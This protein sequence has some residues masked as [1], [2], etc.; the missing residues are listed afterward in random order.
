MTVPQGKGWIGV[1][2]DGTLAHYERW[3]RPDDI[4]APIAPMVGRVKGW[5]ADDWDVRIFTARGSLDAADEALAYPAI[6]RWC[7]EHLGQELPITNRKDVFMVALYDDRAF[8]V[9]K[10]TGHPCD[11]STWCRDAHALAVSK[12]FGVATDIPRALALLHAE[13]SEALEELRKNEDPHH[14]YHRDGDGK[15]EGFTIELADVFLRLANLCGGLGI[16][17]ESAV[18]RKHAFNTTRPH[19]HGKAF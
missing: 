4:G 1:D 19:K 5:L 13:I 7:A 3:V 8:R 18:A 11:L 17:L 12:G 2:L 10:N 16:D 15:P 9:G 6:R 14:T